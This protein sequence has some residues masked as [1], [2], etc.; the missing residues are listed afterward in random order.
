M[1]TTP[2]L[3]R[4][5]K[6]TTNCPECYTTEGLQLE[7]YQPFI[8]NRWYKRFLAQL[9]S[10]MYCTKCKTEIFP[11]SWTPDIERVYDYHRKSTHMRSSERHWKS[12]ALI[13]IIAAIALIAAAMLL[14]FNY[15]R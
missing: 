13:L 6:L 11:V 1:T 5:A 10:K 4:K 15:L 2:K 14:T 9:H 7:F 8:N 3:I 12:I